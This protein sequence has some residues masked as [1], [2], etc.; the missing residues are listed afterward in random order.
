MDSCVM[1]ALSL[2]SQQPKSTKPTQM[3]F[4][5]YIDNT[6]LIHSLELMESATCDVT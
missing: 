6:K 1:N 2:S 3:D 5:V 4:A